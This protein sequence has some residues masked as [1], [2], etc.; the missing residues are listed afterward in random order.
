MEDLDNLD[1][2]P[3]SENIEIKQ[4]PKHSLLFKILLIVFIVTT[5]VLLIIVIIMAVRNKNNEEK[6]EEKE[7]SEELI[8]A[9]AGKTE[10]WNE[11]FGIKLENF[12]FLKVIKWKIHLKIILEIIILKLV[13]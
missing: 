4:N 13:I 2:Q 8:K 12:S 9:Y 6:N 7:N 5:I 3:F 1:K 11:L 10:S